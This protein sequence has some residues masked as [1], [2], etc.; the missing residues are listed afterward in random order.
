MKLLA[1][2]IRK[3]RVS[4]GTQFESGYLRPNIEPNLQQVPDSSADVETTATR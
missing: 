4:S 3:M 1:R 2:T